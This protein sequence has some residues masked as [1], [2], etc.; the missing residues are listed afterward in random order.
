MLDLVIDSDYDD[1]LAGYLVDS[2]FHSDLLHGTGAA[3]T[4]WEQLN[5]FAIGAPNT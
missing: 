3:F 2:G 5:V 4:G 1:N